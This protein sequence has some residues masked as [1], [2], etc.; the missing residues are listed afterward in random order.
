MKKNDLIYKDY[1]KGYAGWHFVKK[2]AG[3]I[4]VWKTPT[5][6]LVC[7]HYE[8]VFKFVDHKEQIEAQ[9]KEVAKILKES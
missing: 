8:G 5:K 2:A 7:A 1:I 6:W 4:E 9:I 3:T